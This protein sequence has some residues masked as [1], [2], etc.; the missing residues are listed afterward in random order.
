MCS[1]YFKNIL[2]NEKILAKYDE[3]LQVIF[4][5]NMYKFC[6]SDKSQIESLINMNRICLILR[7]YDKNKYFEMCCEEHMNMFKDEFIGNKKVMNPT[8]NNRLSNIKNIIDLIIEAQDPN[9]I[10]LCLNY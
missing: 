9:N 5:N 10:F 7:F 6:E 1:N 3:N 4:W 2:L 8:M